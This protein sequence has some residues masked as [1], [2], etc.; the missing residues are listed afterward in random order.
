MLNSNGNKECMQEQA[1]CCYNF[2]L[3]GY[4]KAHESRS[5]LNKYLKRRNLQWGMNG[6][7]ESIFKGK[8][9]TNISPVKTRLV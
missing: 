8:G 4:G 1:M 3:C 2:R 7:R 6:N 5:Y 9:E